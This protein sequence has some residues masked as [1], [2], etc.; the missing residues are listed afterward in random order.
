MNQS[1][2]GVA[3]AVP[4]WEDWIRR[5]WEVYLPT[6]HGSLYRV[7]AEASGVWVYRV[8]SRNT[9]GT[10]K[11]EGVSWKVFRGGDGHWY[12]QTFSA[13]G[14]QTFRSSPVLN[15]KAYSPNL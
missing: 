13:N 1:Q 14:E 8:W 3:H 11:A 10:L 4:A 9:P 5:G 15:D 12:F 6:L 7:I 2:I